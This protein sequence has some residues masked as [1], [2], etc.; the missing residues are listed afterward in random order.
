MK[1]L[2]DLGSKDEGHLTQISELSQKGEE[3]RA[4]EVGRGR[5]ATLKKKIQGIKEAK[6]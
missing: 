2:C 6:N 5:A 4:R 3:K 1:G